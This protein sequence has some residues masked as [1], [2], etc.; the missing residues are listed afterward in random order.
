MLSLAS[1]KLQQA[2][3]YK[4]DILALEIPERKYDMIV[5][6]FGLP[7][8]K[9]CEVDTFVD[10]V[11]RFSSTGTSVYVSC[12]EGDT[13]TREAMSFAGLQSLHVQRH[14]KEDVVASFAKRSFK[15]VSFRKQDYNELDGSVTADLIFFFE[16]M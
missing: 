16:K 11:N 15:L 14:L 2:T 5:C 8:I 6:A 7:Y 12:M 4:S 1:E 13:L 9:T 3:F 10:Q